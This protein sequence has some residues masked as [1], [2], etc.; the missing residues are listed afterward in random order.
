[1]ID[2]EVH[3][4]ICVKQENNGVQV[5]GGSDELPYDFTHYDIGKKQS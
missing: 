5:E 3:K 4:I 2:N 1:M